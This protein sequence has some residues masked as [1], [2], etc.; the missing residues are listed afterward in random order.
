[1]E[2]P[3]G[4]DQRPE[5]TG[6]IVGKKELYFDQAERMFCKGARAST[7]SAGYCR[8][9]QKTLYE[10]KA[11]GDW[12]NQKKAHLASQ[13][14]VADI[15]RDRLAEK[16]RALDGPSFTAGDADEIAKIASTI[17]RLERNAYDLRAAGVEVMTRFG[18]YL[19]SQTDDAAMLQDM[20]KH[21]QGFFEYLETNG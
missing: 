21:I 12:G 16:I 3:D 15:M 4:K 19:R 7:K 6:V 9:P 11:A 8:Y 20:G 5:R 10:W 14:N 2:D 1:M 18:K 17:D 13:R